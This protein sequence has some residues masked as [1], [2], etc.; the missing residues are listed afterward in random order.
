MCRNIWDD[1][2]AEPQGKRPPRI[3]GVGQQH[4]HENDIQM[5]L[6]INE[7]DC[8]AVLG[9]GERLLEYMSQ[10]ACQVYIHNIYPATMDG[11]LPDS[12]E[13]IVTVTGHAHKIPECIGM[14][15]QH[16][17]KENQSSDAPP[18]KVR[19]W[20]MEKAGP[21]GFYG[22]HATWHG[23]GLDHFPN[24]GNKSSATYK[25]IVPPGT[26]SQNTGIIGTP[27]PNVDPMIQKLDIEYLPDGTISIPTNIDQC[28]SI[29]GQS[30]VRIKEIRK[31]S[32]AKIQIND[33]VGDSCLREITINRGMNG[34][35][36]VQNAIWLMNICVNAFTDPEASACPWATPTS[37]QEVVLSGLY[38]K[39]PGMAMQAAAREQARQQSQYQQRQQQQIAA[40]GEGYSHGYY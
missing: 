6:L 26:K 3:M 29:M 10:C 15:C 32:G 33:L 12:N 11:Y 37:L 22:Q 28:G 34:D 1:F 40:S 7:I 27:L 2:Q 23:D 30:G 9:N 39:P 21:C 5:C 25:G 17:L 36:G 38:G 13:K 16:L 14:I 8:P 31:I 4:C 24:F 19:S 35:I 18:G 20:V